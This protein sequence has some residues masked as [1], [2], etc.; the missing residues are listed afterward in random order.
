MEILLVRLT[1]QQRV[2]I[3]QQAKKQKKSEA[4]VVRDAVERLM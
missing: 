4:A 1:H 2:F 3:R